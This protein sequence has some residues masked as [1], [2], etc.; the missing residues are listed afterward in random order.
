MIQIALYEDSISWNH[1]HNY[2]TTHSLTCLGIVPHVSEIDLVWAELEL[3]Q[4]TWSAKPILCMV[5]INYVSF[6]YTLSRGVVRRHQLDS[7]LY[8]RRYCTYRSMIQTHLLIQTQ[9]HRLT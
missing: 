5:S 7:Y 4:F 6:K 2:I 8:Q 1:H 9:L 3:S